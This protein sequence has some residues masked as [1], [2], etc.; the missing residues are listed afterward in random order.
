V[1]QAVFC[2]DR[3]SRDRRQAEYGLLPGYRWQFLLSPLFSSL[4]IVGHGHNVA[5]FK[6]LLVTFS[7]S[8]FYVSVDF[9]GG[10]RR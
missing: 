1:F 8:H 5:Y 9:L 6:V 10:A 4:L 7:S 2:L 3:W